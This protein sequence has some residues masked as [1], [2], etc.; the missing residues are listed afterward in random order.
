MATQ[1]FSSKSIQNKL[2]N[3]ISNSNNSIEDIHRSITEYRGLVPINK[4]IGIL[5]T[6]IRADIIRI[7][8]DDGGFT[9]T[10]E[11]LECFLIFGDLSLMNWAYSNFRHYKTIE[12]VDAIGRLSSYIIRRA[13]CLNYA[14]LILFMQENSPGGISNGYFDYDIINEIIINPTWNDS[15]IAIKTFNFN[16]NN[17]INIIKALET[18]NFSTI[19]KIRFAIDDILTSIIHCGDIETF[20]FIINTYGNYIRLTFRDIITIIFQK[21]SP[22]T[23]YANIHINTHI[24][25]KLA[26]INFLYKEKD[27]RGIIPED[28]FIRIL[29][30][31]NIPPY[32]ILHIIDITYY[33][34]K[35]SDK[36]KFYL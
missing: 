19:E 13:G 5:I 12:G 15:N 31:N 32:Q 4:I 35:T 26:M 11:I 14:S 25:E 21:Q 20:K 29:S 17:T 2:V 30:S 22:K 8:Y 36:I 18:C 10:E 7:I 34:R 9:I 6:F 28:E 16:K 1:D 23:S 27:C 24:E 33:I 3:I